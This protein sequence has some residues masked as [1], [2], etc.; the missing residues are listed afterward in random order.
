MNEK[1]SHLEQKI[2]YYEDFL[3]CL[4]RGEVNPEPWRNW[5]FL[6]IGSSEWYALTGPAWA[7][8]NY[9]YR[10]KP[11]MCDINGHEFPEPL[12]VAPSVGKLCYLPDCVIS[13][14]HSVF[15]Y[16]EANF[17]ERVLKQ[18]Q[19]HATKEAAIDHAKA[20]ILGSGGVWEDV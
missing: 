16:H 20:M 2:E 19:L 17:S 4:K 8:G 1:T 18:G 14:F 5:Q 6:P 10:R 7:N 15:I 9:K 12:R 3:D 11:K 13:D